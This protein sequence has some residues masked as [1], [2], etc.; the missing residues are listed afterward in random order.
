MLPP[1]SL[2]VLDGQ[3]LRVINGGVKIIPLFLFGILLGLPLDAQDVA[4]ANENAT[5]AA[6][7]ERK[8]MEATLAEV[9][10][11]TG[12]D[13]ERGKKFLKAQNDWIAYV[14][15]QAEADA[16]G[17]SGD[18]RYPQSYFET[19]RELTRYR[20]RALEGCLSRLR[21]EQGGSRSDVTGGAGGG[22]GGQA[23]V[24]DWK[25]EVGDQA[26]AAGTTLYQATIEGVD[27]IVAGQWR[28]EAEDLWRGVFLA[29]RGDMMILYG[30]RMERGGVVFEAWQE[31]A[32]IGRGYLRSE[33]GDATW[34]GRFFDERRRESPIVLRPITR[35]Q[36][37]SYEVALTRYTGLVGGEEAEL[38]LE[39]H[40]SRYVQGEFGS[41]RVKGHNYDSGKLFLEEWEAGEGGRLVGLWSLEKI[42][43]GSSTRWA[44]RLVNEEG[45]LQ[46]VDFGR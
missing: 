46:E 9:L 18:A 12:K 21:A 1:S 24:R 26:V 23:K 38:G 39:W 28:G 41:H 30:G 6:E 25:A 33:A 15:T 3:A 27:G 17:V 20:T 16:D 43:R 37:V 34:R 2:A 40:D 32:R 10:K 35:S 31:N 45:A 42:K 7:N 13:T 36:P 29:D 8:I 19:M 4:T 44:G 5:A 11:L 14:K 22:Q